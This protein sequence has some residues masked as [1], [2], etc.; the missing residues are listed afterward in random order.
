[1]SIFDKAKK[2][3]AK[4]AAAKKT[5][6][7]IAIAGIQSLAEIKAMMQN[8]E[9]VAKTLEGEV[10]EAG[11]A[12]F[13]EM[14]TNIRPESFKG[15][16]G[17]AT[18]SVEMRKRSTA[19]ALNADEVEL[20]E[21]MGLKPFTQVVTTEM[22]GI[23]P[24]Y[25]ANEELMNKVS[26]ALE[27]I[28][29]EDFIVLQAGVTKQVVDDALCDAAFKMP[30]GEDRATALRMVTT[31]A[32]KP[33]LNADYPME[34]LASN[35]SKYLVPEVKE[36]AKVADLEAEAVALLES[37]TTTVTTTTTTKKPRSKKATPQD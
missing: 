14:E 7:E 21:K 4:P 2:V 19:S 12:K 13:L 5:K 30:A 11:F 17:M 8:L 9:A 26:K 32:L 10:K 37:T 35:V 29:P 18:W 15:V 16:D 25:A 28:V 6:Q 20:L 24:I 23:N 31:M 34:A 22:F 3:E 1:M 33:K 27:K 36:E